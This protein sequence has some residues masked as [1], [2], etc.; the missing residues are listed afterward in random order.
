MPYLSEDK[1]RET[2]RRIG[3]LYEPPDTLAW[4]MHRLRDAVGELC[5]S[6]ADALQELIGA[7]KREEKPRGR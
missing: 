7:V 5:G 1:V 3:H 2:E 6:L 4:S